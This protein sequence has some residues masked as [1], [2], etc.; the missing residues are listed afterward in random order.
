MNSIAVNNFGTTSTDL[1]KVRADAG[2]S[3]CHV[4]PVI[5]KIRDHGPAILDG[6]FYKDDVRK[7]GV[8]KESTAALPGKA[9][10]STV[11][12]AVAEATATP[13]V[14]QLPRRGVY[15]A[16]IF[17]IV[18]LTVALVSVGFY[19]YQQKLHVN[20]LQAELK[21]YDDLDKDF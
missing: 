8:R 18:L 21:I 14:S 20:D 2:Q 4:S 3:N 6:E 7:D 17:S 1:L 19:A 5:Y 16:M 11:D 9:K 10:A 13:V 15:K 12:I